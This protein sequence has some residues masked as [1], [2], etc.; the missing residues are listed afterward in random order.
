MAEKTA[1]NMIANYFQRTRTRASF[2][3]SAMAVLSLA[4]LGLEV[5]HA[6]VIYAKADAA[7]ANNG[8][9]WVDAYTEL[10]AALAAANPGDEIW[11][12]AG[13]YKPDYDVTGGTHTGDRIRR[14]SA[15]VGQ[16]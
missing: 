9:N 15:V 16:Q 7:G 11:V 1:L 3:V 14:G 2:Q 8:A 13:T 4:A 6:D 10:Q 12:A 5:A